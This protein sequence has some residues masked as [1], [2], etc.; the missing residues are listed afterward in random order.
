MAQ[1]VRDVAVAC[2]PEHVFAVLSS[3]ERLAEF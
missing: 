3:V 2:P 1:I